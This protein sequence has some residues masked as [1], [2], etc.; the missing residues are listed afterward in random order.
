MQPR[1][2]LNL[3]LVQP[4]A[5]EPCPAKCCKHRYKGRALAPQETDDS[6]IGPVG[7]GLPTPVRL[8]LK[9]FPGLESW[10]GPFTDQEGQV[11]PEGLCVCD[12]GMATG[13]VTS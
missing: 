1:L 2:V 8:D 10:S 7:V 6:Y 4:P 3:C 5:S 13:K 9:S 12:S 11:G